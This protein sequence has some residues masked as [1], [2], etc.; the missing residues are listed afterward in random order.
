MRSPFRLALALTLCTATVGCGGVKEWLKQL[1]GEDAADAIDMETGLGELGETPDVPPDVG[2]AVAVP[3]SVRPL[4]RAERKYPFVAKGGSNMGFRIASHA[5]QY[6]LDGAM[7]VPEWSAP[8]KGDPRLVRDDDLDTAWRCTPTEYDRCALGIHFPK[9]A[10]FRAIRIFSAPNGKDASPIKRLRI[11][12]DAGFADALLPD[13]GS[14]TYAVFGT[15]LDTYNLI[16]EVLETADGDRA[17]IEIAEFELFGT[18]GTPRPGLDLDPR[19]SYVQLSKPP[20]R[21]KGRESYEFSK[22]FIHVTDDE[23]KPHRFIRGSGLRGAAGD[24]LLLIERVDGQIGCGAPQGTFFLLDQKTRM[25][26]PLGELAGIGG[27]TFRTKDGN[28]IVTGYDGKLATVLHGVFF[29]EGIYK[30]KHTPLRRDKAA[31]DYFESWDLQREPLPRNPP[32]L[33]SPPS[34]CTVASDDLLVELAAAKGDKSV[35]DRPGQWLVCDLGTTHR[36]FVTDRGPCG[37]ST[38]IYVL[39]ADAK[40]VLSKVFKSAD[41]HVGLFRLDPQTLLAEVGGANDK[42]TLVRV[43]TESIDVVAEHAAV[44]APPPSGCRK[45]CDAPFPNPNAP[46]YD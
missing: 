1:A 24:R 34:N 18:E 19:R 32:G 28:G 25:I 7:E 37:R 26:S 16:I 6:A 27:D 46:A 33:R 14:H 43:N 42:S 9:K 10:S 45:T 22:G 8:S 30:Q 35:E 44:A 39:D 21:K 23:G 12:T 15:D 36:A 2:E 38:E 29:E 31:A 17:P 41:S 4:V 13:S 40:L 11:H 3:E 20:W 5:E